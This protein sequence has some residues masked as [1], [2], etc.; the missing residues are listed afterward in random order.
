MKYFEEDLNVQKFVRVHR[1][2]IVNL[3]RLESLEP[4][5]KETRML[6]FRGG[7]K[8]NVSKRGMKWLNSLMDFKG[9]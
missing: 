2:C 4:H 9:L 8:V 1:P 7:Y 3:E 5:G 6:T